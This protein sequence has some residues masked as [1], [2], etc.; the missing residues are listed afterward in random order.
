MAASLT[1]RDREAARRYHRERAARRLA[2]REA[3]RGYWLT[4]AREAILRLAPGHGDIRRVY[5]FGSLLRPGCFGPGSDI[6]VAILCDLETEVPFW[7]SLEQGLGRNVDL[8]PLVEPLATN[9]RETGEL[10]YEREDAHPEPQ[11]T[12]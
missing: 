12:A 7:R 10:V 3:E 9:V 8:R 4:R 5:L 2:Q 11:H 1:N 6:D